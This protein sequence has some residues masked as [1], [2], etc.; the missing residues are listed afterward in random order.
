MLKTE[1]FTVVPDGTMVVRSRQAGDTIRL[2]GGTKE[3]KKLFIDR[4]IPAND[5]LAIPVIADDSGV[6][7]EYGLGA[8]LNRVSGDGDLVQLRFE[9]IDLSGL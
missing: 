5:R 9:K 7:G 6:L 4:K 8:N 3:L 1:H 2:S